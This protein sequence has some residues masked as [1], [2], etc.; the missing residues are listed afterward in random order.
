MSKRGWII[1]IVIVALNIVAIL[2]RWNSLPE[3]LPA[4]FDLQGNAGGE[5]SR[6]TLFLYP[7]IGAVICGIAYAIACIIY[8]RSLNKEKANSVANGLVFL[9]SGIALVILSS[10]L[11]TLTFGKMPVFMLAEPVFLVTAIVAFIICI[12]KARRKQ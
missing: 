3:L 11:V 5:M 9:V 4:H 6:W 10:T 8:K 7:M 12:F 1:P 2:I